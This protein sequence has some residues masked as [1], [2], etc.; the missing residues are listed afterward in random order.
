L[1]APLA[2]ALAT[3]LRCLSLV[4]AVVL[5]DAAINRRLVSAS[6]LA[7]RLRGPGS[8]AARIALAAVDGRAESML[9]TVLRLGLRRAGLPVTPQAWVAGVGRVDFLI[10]GWLVVEV[11]GYA[12]HSS[13]NDYREDR[14]RGNALSADGYVLLRFSYEDVMFRLDEVVAQVLA[15]YEA[16]V[17]RP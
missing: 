8:V 11:D 15:T 12:F 13:R 14:R 6:T 9:E 3:A 10:G 17:S 5:V 16:G 1:V 7:A 2:A 4:N